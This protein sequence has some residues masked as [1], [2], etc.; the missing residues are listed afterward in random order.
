MIEAAVGRYNSS[1]GF[2]S[3]MNEY[4]DPSLVEAMVAVESGYNNSAYTGDPMQVNV[5][6]DWVKEK[7]GYG[8]TKGVSPGAELSISAGIG[9]LVYKSYSRATWD[10]PLTFRGW[11][12]G[13]TRYNGGGDPNYL[14]KVK[15]A[16]A[17]ILGGC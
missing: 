5:P 4:L 9:W 12:A 16:Q 2:V 14:A 17:S 10:G 7:T 11:D 15:A 1:K 6:G 3:G 8:L 13:V